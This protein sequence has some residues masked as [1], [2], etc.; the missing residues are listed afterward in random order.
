[1]VKAVKDV[2]DERNHQSAT[3]YGGLR[4]GAIGLGLGA[5]G[6]IALQRSGVKAYRSLTLPL[7]AFALTSVT[8][9]A[10]II[11]ADSASR[12]YELAKYSIGSDSDLARE[13]RQGMQL[14]R[15]AGIAG[16][17]Q[18]NR[19]TLSTR[20]ALIEFG[21]T[22][23]YGVVF[24]AWAASMVGSFGYISMTPLSFAQKLVQA[25]MVAQGLTVAVLIASAGLSAIPSTASGESEDQV[26]RRER[27]ES[28][29]RWKK[30]SQHDLEHSASL[31]K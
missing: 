4:A 2:Q 30:G 21:K 19:P 1:M 5:V 7:K 3:V 28:M 11:G 26:K 29:F 8:T 14:E 9:A 6:S 15:E 20:D 25:R 24:G 10:F 17:T 13:A 16:E 22:H 27:E 23:R 18:Q 31:T 12:E